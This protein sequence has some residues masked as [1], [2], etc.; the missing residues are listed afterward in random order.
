MKY[1]VGSKDKPKK[2]PIYFVDIDI[3]STIFYNDL[4]LEEDDQSDPKHQK[5]EWISYQK[6]DEEDGLWN[7]DF[8]G[9]VSKE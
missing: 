4:C 9:V 1:M 7:M 2:H 3:G 8:D 6:N 5:A